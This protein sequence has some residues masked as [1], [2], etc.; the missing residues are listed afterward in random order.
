M[1]ERIRIL[2]TDTLSLVQREHPLVVDRLKA[3]PRKQRGITVISL[4]EQLRGRLAQIAKAKGEEELRRAYMLLEQTH[5][6]LCKIQKFAFDA[7]AQEKFK[8][9]KR[10]KIRIG[11]LDLRIAAIAL[12]N[13]AILVTRNRQDFAKIPELDL[14]DWSIAVEPA[15]PHEKR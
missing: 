15:L 9:L 2:D 13:N 3:V 4:E 7:K 14:E 1:D 11:T 12:S 5:R 6:G 8:E 10:A